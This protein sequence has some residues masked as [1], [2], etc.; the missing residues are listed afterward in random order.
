[1]DVVITAALAPSPPSL[2]P[3][4]AGS[5]PEAG[6]AGGALQPV[7]VGSCVGVWGPASVLVVFNCEPSPLSG[8]QATLLL[9]P[10]GDAR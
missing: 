1:M 3:S 4:R 6:G 9:L 2:V 7:W 5:P 8:W 10:R